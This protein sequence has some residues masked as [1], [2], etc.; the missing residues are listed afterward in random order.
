MLTFLAWNNKCF[1][2]LQILGSQSGNPEENEFIGYI[3]V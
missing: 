2:M 1:Q 3:A